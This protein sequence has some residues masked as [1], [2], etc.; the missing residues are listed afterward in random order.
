MFAPRCATLHE[1]IDQHA[2][3]RGV[4]AQYCT[5]EKR[6]ITLTRV[7]GDEM[8]RKGFSCSAVCFFQ[9]A[10]PFTW[11]LSMSISWD[12]PYEKMKKNAIPL[13]EVIILKPK[14]AV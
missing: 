8:Q 14:Y 1:H 9:S 6:S 13:R 11:N 4:A 5:G 10:G 2:G 3:R 7:A 12:V